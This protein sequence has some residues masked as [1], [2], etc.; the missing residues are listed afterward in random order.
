M[1]NNLRRRSVSVMILYTMT[2]AGLLG[3]L[4]G[5][6]PHHQAPGLNDSA[7]INIVLEGAITF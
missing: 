7:E 6:K 2:V 3:S 4:I 5:C 1:S